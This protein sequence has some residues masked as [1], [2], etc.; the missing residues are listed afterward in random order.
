[1]PVYRWQE[2]GKCLPA[3][4]ESYV[5]A[6]VTHA[7][8][9]VAD[10][11]RTTAA[12]VPGFPGIVAFGADSHE[13]ARNLYFSLEEWV[14]TALTHGYVLPVVNGIDLNADTGQILVTY[15]QDSGVAG[16]RG[17]FFENEAALGAKRRSG[18]ARAS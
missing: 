3:I 13:C 17:D 9:E 2:P 4:V 1:M 8:A 5:F 12:H 7:A 14:R 6:V 11:Q 10:D 16:A 18:N 15:H